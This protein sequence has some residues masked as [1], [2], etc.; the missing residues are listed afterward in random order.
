[1]S[2]NGIL[3]RRH[4]NYWTNSRSSQNHHSTSIIEGIAGIAAVAKVAV[5]TGTGEH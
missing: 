3:I 4:E 5:G 2:R 1:M